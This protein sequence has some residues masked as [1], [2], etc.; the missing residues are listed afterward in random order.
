MRNSLF[1]SVAVGAL[2]SSVC[3]PETALAQAVTSADDSAPTD[4]IVVTA[5]RSDENLQ[6]VPISIT[7]L[8]QQQISQRNIVNASDLAIYTPSL[9]ANSRFGPEKSSFAIRGFGQ[10]QYTAP[11]VGVYFADVVA[12]RSGSQQTAGNGAGPGS[13]FDLQNVQVLKGPQGTLFGRNT[14]GGAILLVPTKPTSEFGGY[15]EGT[16]GDYDL[17]RIQGAL[18][19]PLTETFR[20]RFAIDRNKRDGYLTNHS[21]IGP[22][23]YSDVN[24]TSARMSVVG[25]LTPNLENYMIASFSDSDTVGTPGRL[26]VCNPALTSTYALNSCDQV[27][28]ARARGDG[29]WDVDVGLSSPRLHVKQWQVIDTTTWRASDS[30]TIKNIVSYSEY[31]EA[32]TTT[33]I[34]ANFTVRAQPAGNPFAPADPSDVGM[35]FQFVVLNPSPNH[36]NTKQQNFTEELQ[37]QGNIGHRLKW[38]AGGYLEISTPP[39]FNQ[40]YS[41]TNLNCT[42][43]VALQCISPLGADGA[44]GALNDQQSKFYY[45]TKAFYA[46]ATYN[47]TSQ[48]AITGGIRY[49]IDHLH[50]IDQSTR[51]RFPTAGGVERF[52]QNTIEFQN[53]DHSMLFVN[54]PVQCRNRFKQNS[55]KPT[56]LIDAEYKPIEDI[57]LYAKYSRGYRQGGIAPNNIGLETWEPEKVDLY[58][59]GAKTRF[60]SGGVRGYFNFAGFYNDL[61]NQQITALLVGRPG[62]GSNG[63]SAIVNAG[64]S[65]IKGIEVD[66]S[67]TF[68]DQFK[69]DAGYTY[70]DTRVKK[71]VEPEIPVDGPF[72]SVTPTASE[73]DRLPLSPKHRLSLTGT[74]T[75]PLDES[76]GA[77]SVGATYVYTA[78][79]SVIKGSPFGTLPASNLINLNVDW[80]E[81]LGN[82]VDLSFFMTNVTNDDTPVSVVGIYNT[83][84]GE[85]AYMGA[86]RMWGL[87]LRYR[88]GN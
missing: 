14:T 4:E 32:V 27:A 85:V 23:R 65:T 26:F 75:L 33:L 12:P 17:R 13:F 58:E 50:V 40:I 5:R 74:W 59:V 11:S 80:R 9:S 88:F 63:G 24:Y 49:T 86:P 1:A 53:P 87:R 42:N 83:I 70:L 37:F 52:C 29:P 2:W 51:V 3:L 43:A 45:N 34:G 56:W 69:V 82:P 57:M 64:K 16:A 84:G 41:A 44:V 77:V 21:G 28:R 71:I 19:V 18:N 48:L 39:Y 68:F 60:H 79:Q 46:Q 25:D 67:M 30:L 78:S 66:S 47:L 8:N 35:P 6:D 55:S 61:T 10:E 36:G 72:L 73:G 20:V 54:D 62:S 31:Q 81:V 22:K 76:I 38:Q 15:I 7:V